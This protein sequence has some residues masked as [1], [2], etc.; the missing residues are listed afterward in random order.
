[1]KFCSLGKYDDASQLTSVTD[2]MG[3]VTSYGYDDLG[4][5]KDSTLSAGSLSQQQSYGYD[6][7]GNQTRYT[8]AAGWTTFTTYDALNRGV[9]TL[10]PRGGITQFTFDAVGNQTSLTDAVGNTT[11]WVYDRLNRQILDINSLGQA[12]RFEYDAAGNLTRRT[13]RRGLVTQYDYNARNQRTTEAWFDNATQ[14]NAYLADPNDPNAAPSQAYNFGYDSLGRFNN[15][16]S[17]SQGTMRTSVSYGYD[18]YGRV[19]SESAYL[20]G[21]NYSL[22]STYD[23]LNQRVSLGLN[24]DSYGGSYVAYHYEYDNLGR[25]RAVSETSSTGANEIPQVSSAGIRAEFDYNGLGQLTQV[26]RKNSPWA[27]AAAA[28]TTTYNYDGLQRLRDLTHAGPGGSAIAGYSFD[29]DARNQLTARGYSNSQGANQSE[30]FAYDANGQLTGVNHNGSQTDESYVHDLNGNRQDKSGTAQTVGANN[31]LLNDGFFA[32]T[33]DAEGNRLTKTALVNGQPTGEVTTYHY[34]HRDRMDQVAIVHTDGT[35]IIVD[36]LYDAFDHL[37]GRTET[38]Y[39]ASNNVVSAVTNYFLYDGNQ[40][41]ATLDGSGNV[42]ERYLWGPGVDNL[43]AIEVVAS[44]GAPSGLNQG[45][46]WVLADQQGTVRDLLDASG[47]LVWHGDYDTFGNLQTALPTGTTLWFGYTGRLFDVTTGLQNN[48]HRWYDPTTG[49]WLS[50]DP[51]GFGGG[52]TSLADYVGNDP[53]NE[54]DPSGFVGD[55]HHLVPQ[56]KWALFNPDVAKK[57]FDPDNARIRNDAYAFHNGKKQNGISHYK[58]NEAVEEEAKK[59]FGNKNLKE[60]TEEE[61]KQFL[62]HIKSRKDCLIGKFNAGVREEA[63]KA[64]RDAEKAAGKQ[65][66]KNVDKNADKC[67]DRQFEKAADRLEKAVDKKVDKAIEKK[68]VKKAEDGVFKKIGKKVPLIGT[69]ITV[70]FWS[71]DVEAKGLVG[72]TANSA[73]DAIPFF[74]WGKMGVEF[75]T[76]P[77]IPDKEPD[78]AAPSQ[79]PPYYPNYGGIGSIGGSHSDKFLP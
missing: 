40:I 35:S 47:N 64:L 30:A 4:R 9:Q 25:Q 16:T 5:L 22:S 65:L 46:Y 52:L 66:K 71:E 76:G 78:C 17:V 36:N 63:E 58:Y 51:I 21:L 13:D 42:V 23:N 48:W 2:T 43:L 53:V 19:N 61:A 75:F 56:S 72:G 44:S 73:M 38:H 14:A 59:I 55:G 57:V 26:T 32:Y 6:A 79:A 77:W 70:W 20:G 69:I 50:E 7:V 49:R 31:Q 12:R 34:D 54:A 10:D 62:E 24:Y 11:T 67:I 27:A 39:D 3:R 28:N 33:Y 60:V 15:A 1:M 45:V 41:V 37:I 29:Y 18:Y 74:S 8:D 68:S